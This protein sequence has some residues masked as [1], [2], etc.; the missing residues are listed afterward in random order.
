M[1]TISIND[2]SVP[3]T[4]INLGA[5]IN[6]MT[7]ETMKYLKLPNIRPTITGLELA[8]RSKVVPKGILED[9]IVSLDSWEY[10]V[11]FLILQP[12]TNLGGHTLI[13]GRPWLATTDAFIG[14]R[15]GSII[16]AHGDERKHITLYLLAQSPSLLSWPE[17]EQ[18]NT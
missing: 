5:T 12:K 16:I 11:Y 3:S 17:N 4:L 7:T 1:V 10:P 8:D 14:Y 18:V 13:L 6:V 2:F 9:I 15:S